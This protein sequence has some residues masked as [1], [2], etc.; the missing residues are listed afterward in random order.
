M[1]KPDGMIRGVNWNKNNQGEKMKRPKS[2]SPCSKLPVTTTVL[3][4][5]ALVTLLISPGAAPY[6]PQTGAV[7]GIAMFYGHLT[8]EYRI[9]VA[10]SL[11][12]DVA[13]VASTSFDGP[14]G[15][16]YTI[17]GLDPGS[18]IISALIFVGHDNGP[19]VAGDPVGFYDPNHDGDPDY[20]TVGSSGEKKGINI[21]LNLAYETGHYIYYVDADATGGNDGS[22]WQDAF[23][24]LQSA[25]AAA[26]ISGTEIWMAD[27]TYKPT[28]GSDRNATFQLK[29]NIAIYGGF[30]GTET[31]RSERQKSSHVTILSGDIN[32]IGTFTD[33]SYHVVTGSGTN[34]TAILADVT[35]MD[36]NAGTAS[37]DLDKGG[38]MLINTGYPVVA[39]VRFIHNN[40]YYHGGGIA[41]QGSTTSPALVINC[42]F[43]GN[44]ANPNGAGIAAFNNSKITIINSTFTGNNS[45]AG[46]LTIF[47]AGTVATIRNIILYGN[48][49]KQMDNGNSATTSLTYSIIQG[50]CPVQ[51]GLTCANITDADPLFVDANGPDD[52][53]GTLD[54]N[55]TLQAA[56]PAIDA[57]TNDGVPADFADLDGDGDTTEPTPLDSNLALRF[58]DLFSVADTGSGTAPIIDIG[59]VEF[60]NLLYVAVAR[61]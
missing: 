1:V 23:T 21:A 43:S 53:F 57:G 52:T 31:L 32:T 25:L 40:G 5:I 10:A 55:Y 39:N 12:P 11:A 30:A 27:G 60:Q 38:G 50:G 35:I 36:G 47:T 37:G 15:G 51:S 6:R 4:L 34:N 41:I 19:P 3:L 54:D 17:D 2:R 28:A 61:R 22:C 26:T 29:N 59:A 16:P 7:S 14:G 13:P 46:A 9:V 49:P 42:T 56:S 44:T 33:N 8:S 24:S 20:V 18:Y 58:V 48:T 45:A